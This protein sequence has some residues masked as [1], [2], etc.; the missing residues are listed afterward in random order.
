MKNKKRKKN[1]NL[2]LALL[3]ICYFRLNRKRRNW[4]Y[5]RY[6]AELTGNG[7]KWLK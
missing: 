1:K 7:K 6:I 4:T 2:K 3:I 5:R